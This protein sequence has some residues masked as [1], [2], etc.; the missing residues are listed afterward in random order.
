MPVRRAVRV[1]ARRLLP[2]A[3]AGLAVALTACG[4]G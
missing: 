3:L 2:V 4:G 1:P